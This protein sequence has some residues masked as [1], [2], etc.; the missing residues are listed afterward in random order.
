MQRVPAA[1]A[2]RRPRRAR[3]PGEDAAVG[4]EHHQL[5][6]DAAEGVAHHH[7]VGGAA[8]GAAVA[9]HQRQVGDV[10]VGVDHQRHL[11]S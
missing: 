11:R 1:R 8:E 7:L 10:A 5:V 3:A 4:A 6:G 9:L 2:R